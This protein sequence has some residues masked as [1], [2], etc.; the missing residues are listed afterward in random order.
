MI[1]RLVSITVYKNQKRKIASG[2]QNDI[3][4]LMPTNFF[5]NA[6]SKPTFINL[7]KKKKFTLTMKWIRTLTRQYV[8][9]LFL[10]PFILTL[11]M[12]VPK[13]Q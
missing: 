5:L 9:K 4:S 8:L 6:D 7:S 10:Q 11:F 1:W 12:F 3:S 13:Y 2:T